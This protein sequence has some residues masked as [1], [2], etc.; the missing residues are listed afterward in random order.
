MILEVCLIFLTLYV[1]FL[2]LKPK[3]NLPPGPMGIP[4]IG[5]APYCFV[6]SC[7]KAKSKY[8]NIFMTKTGATNIV[9]ICNYKTAKEALSK[10]EL[11]D[12][13]HW[14]L[15][16]F[17]KEEREKGRAGG[18]VGSNGSHWHHNRRFLLRHLRDL[19]MG[20]S[21]IEGIILREVENLV[22]EFKKLTKEPSLFPFS[23]NIS[24]LNIIWQLV[25]SHRY[26]F[27][28]E[29][30][31]NFMRKM[32][33]LQNE[34]LFVG[35]QDF[36][37]ILN[38][39]IP[40]P[41]LKFILGITKFEKASQEFYDLMK[42]FINEHLKMLDP[43]N[44]RDLMDDYLIEM[45]EGKSEDY[46][47]FSITAV[48]TLKLKVYY[49]IYSLVYLDATINEVQR[50][51]SLVPLGIFRCATDDLKLEG[52]DI[53]KGTVVL[54]SLAAL[55]HRDRTYFKDPDEFDPSRFIDENGKYIPTC[56]GFQ[57]FGIGKRQCLGEQ[58]ARMELYFIIG[59][60]L[61]NF[62]FSAPEG[63]NPISLEPQRVPNM[64]Y[65]KADQ[66]FVI[67]YRN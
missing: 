49:R 26:N 12:R 23:A 29:E 51:C 40:K 47:H 48:L 17:F 15:F 16:N 53:P 5:G 50:H 59:A 37:P 21:K 3:G 14:K 36:F 60:L 67:K 8:G 61:Q 35:L 46:S 55:S 65:P 20:K 6:D 7:I 45:T 44:P 57:A 25:A 43:S 4:F 38:Y 63:E 18:I 10:L 9:Y 11:A 58:F 13:P 42:P 52:Y 32:G 2:Y 28:D 19:G 33:Q 30:V 22:E 62:T 39:I 66:K 56:D 31:E 34:F 54:S 1:M 41:I 24:I 27:E 64:N